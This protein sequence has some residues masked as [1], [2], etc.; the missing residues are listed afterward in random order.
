M[1][2]PTF[3]SI[4]GPT[5]VGKTNLALQLA[6]LPFIQ[7]KF[8]GVDIISADSRQVY[9]GLEII[10]GVDMPV[11]FQFHQSKHE[12]N[13]AS[14]FKYRNVNIHGVLIKNPNQDWSLAHFREFAQKIITSG[15]SKERL[16]II[17][18]GTGLYHQ[19]L[20]SSDPT[21]NIAPDLKVREKATQL[22]IGGL[23]DW[24]KAINLKRFNQMNQSD[25]LN[26]RRLIRAIE[27]ELSGF[28]QAKKPISINNTRNVSIGL[29]DTLDHI[30]L[31]IEKRVVNRFKNGA[32]QEVENLL[33]LEPPPTKQVLSTIGV[34][35]IEQF[36]RH[37]LE[38]A[39]AI[40]NWTRREF[41]YAK[42]QLTWWKKYGQAK[43]FDIN[44]QNWLAD[45][46]NYLS[47][48]LNG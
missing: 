10:S 2:Q 31:K 3:I 28:S 25:K 19:Y 41:Q 12:S 17:V 39:D 11:N 13:E 27:V 23:Q 45:V 32:I 47:K 6:E 29:I 20:L 18:G 14:L 44:N 7:K 1:N 37:G 34:R 8:S 22:S 21:I 46:V 38:E 16:P 30:K 42:R 35:E 48:E 5:A 43:W 33:S 40:F 26:P 36:L 4:I 24:L 15:W 9:I